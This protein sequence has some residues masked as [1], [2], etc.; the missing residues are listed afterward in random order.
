MYIVTLSHALFQ[1]CTITIAES[2]VANLTLTQQSSVVNKR[3]K[4][5]LRTHFMALELDVLVDAATKLNAHLHETLAPGSVNWACDHHDDPH[6][7]L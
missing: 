2:E 7:P 3:L 1:G 4:E 6:C 5:L